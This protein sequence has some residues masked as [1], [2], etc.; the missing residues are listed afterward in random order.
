MQILQEVEVLSVQK[1]NSNV[2]KK[3]TPVYVG[4]TPHA[5]RVGKEKDEKERKM[6]GLK[7]EK[8]GKRK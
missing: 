7:W 1:G 4:M 6:K 8:I 5:L 2:S 3:D